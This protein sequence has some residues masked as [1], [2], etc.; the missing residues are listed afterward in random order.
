MPFPL[1]NKLL[2][3]LSKLKK[4][5][6]AGLDAEGIKVILHN[7]NRVN[8]NKNPITLV[9]NDNFAEV[10]NETLKNH[11]KSKPGRYQFIVKSGAHYTTVDLEIDE[12]GHAKALVL[13]AANDMRFI[14]LLTKLSSIEGIERVYYAEGKTNRDNI[15]KD[16]ISCPVFALSHAMALQSLDIYNHLEQEEV[17]KHKMLGDKIVGASWN[18]MP[19][20][21]NI[22]C[23]SSTLWNTYKKEYQE[24]FG[25]EDNYFEKYDQYRDEMHRKS[26]V[27]E[28]S[29]CDQ[30]GNIIPAVF[31]RIVVPA[32]GDVRQ[33]TE[34]ELKG[35]IY[36][37]TAISKKTNELLDSISNLIQTTNWEKLTRA[38]DK[39]KNVIAIEQILGN[40]GMNVYDRLEKIQ[41]VC[42]SAH[43]SDFEFLFSSAFRGR[44][45]FTN[46]LYGIL[47]DVKV[48]DAKSLDTA[49]LT[50]N[51]LS[52]DQPK[53]ARLQ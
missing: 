43:A 36:E 49:L 30:V 33:M 25:L 42:K 22:N 29:I 2:A 18:H 41:E 20:A 47:G 32:L 1:R 15:Q 13:D 51:Q 16:N 26:A 50:L 3:Q 6:D 44:D 23:Q 48:T 9:Q 17:D 35:I 19:P 7:H 28:P 21:I 34:S 5:H 38:G 39:P 46:E 14:P 45:A 8:P 53:A 37:G 52:L 24:A 11:D 31:Q 4:G 27:I 12:Q 40:S 10:I